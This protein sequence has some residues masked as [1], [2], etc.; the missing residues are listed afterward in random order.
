MNRPEFGSRDRVRV[1][2]RL[3]RE[4]ADAVYSWSR[5]WN[6]SLSEAGARLIE[7]RL[8]QLASR[9]GSEAET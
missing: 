8:E 7:S 3:P 5:K 2:F 9:P 1:E 4:T 6:V